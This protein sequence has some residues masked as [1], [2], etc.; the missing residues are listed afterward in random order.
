MAFLCVVAAMVFFYVLLITGAMP[1][2]LM[3]MDAAEGTFWARFLSSGVPAG[4]GSAAGTLY[5]N[6]ARKRREK[7]A[8]GEAPR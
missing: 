7:T 6:A 1:W 4:V 3:L 8:E 5:L 2:Y